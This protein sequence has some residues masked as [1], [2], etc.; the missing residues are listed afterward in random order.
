[1]SNLPSPA[2][3]SGLQPPRRS[4]EDPGAHDLDSSENEDDHFSD[5]SE[6][7][8]ATRT[9]SPVPTTRV[10]KVDGSPRHGDVPGTAAYD[11]RTQDAVP[12]EVEITGE[13]DLDTSHSGDEQ[14]PITRVEKVDSE[15]PSHGEVPGTKAHEIRQAD[16]VPDLVVKMPDVGE[17]VEG[18]PR[19]RSNS[20][21]GDRPIPM[22]KVSKVD[23]SP[24]HGDVP[25]TEA[26]EKRRGDAQPDI[27]E[28]EPESPGTEGLF[29]SARLSERL[30][31]SGVPTSSKNRSAIDDHV[32]RASSTSGSTS[33][34]AEDDEALGDVD[35]ED[36]GF[37]DDFDEFEEGE[38]DAEFGDFDD[39]FQRA[40]APAPYESSQQVPSSS[41]TLQS[42]P[43]LSEPLLD[44]SNLDSP[45]AVIAATR[46][47]LTDI[48]PSEPDANP[49]QLPPLPKDD[50]IFL[51]DR[52]YTPS[53]SAISH[54]PFQ[55]SF[56]SI[57]RADISSH[58]LSLSLW[59][60]LVAPPPLQPPNWIRSRIRRLFLVSLGVP[61]DL[62]EILPASKQQKLVLPIT[63]GAGST[64]THHANSSSSSLPSRSGGGGGGGGGGKRKGPPPPPQLDLQ[65]ARLLAATTE[66][67]MHGMGEEEMRSFVAELEKVVERAAEV[68]RWWDGRRVELRKEKEALEA[69]IGD[70][71]RHAR[72]VRK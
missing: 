57:L 44:F 20:T 55:S 21:P 13:P 46:E 35:D 1:M 23:A 38:E 12:D 29:P 16:A 18:A 60:Q 41:T 63:S 24:S 62:D 43:P 54:R 72:R 31:V 53:L 17:P 37:G 2:S 68:E 26:W 56:I 65:A 47:R 10:E 36:G 5:A 42:L 64:G 33:E 14:I 61:V 11:L 40:E 8:K 4:L 28:E 67:K 32:Q 7:R 9:E 15:T 52:R 6:G 50:S 39:A 71:V 3:P 58:N 49:P 51:T 30:T 48:F 27:V 22:T 66:E 69:V 25:G 45:A 34:P 70:L 59:T 19:S